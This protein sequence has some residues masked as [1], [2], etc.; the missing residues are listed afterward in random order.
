MRVIVA[1][2]LAVFLS[3]CDGGLW[4]NPYPASDDGKS[5]FYTAFTER[6]INVFQ[7]VNHA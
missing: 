6:P 2:L 1:C 5:I 7:E 3:A 4:N